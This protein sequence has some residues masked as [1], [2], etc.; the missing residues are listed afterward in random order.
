MAKKNEMT[1][2][3]VKISN[4]PLL[5]KP[6]EEAGELILH[7]MGGTLAIGDLPPIKFPSGGS[8]VYQIPRLD[9]DKAVDLFEAVILYR[10]STINKAYW[11]SITVTKTPPDCRSHDG[12]TGIGDPGGLCANC[13]LNKFGSAL[14]ASGNPLP[15]KAC[16]DRQM[17]F[18]LLEGD[19]LPY[20]L[21]LPPTSLRSFGSFCATL[22]QAARLYYSGI[23][24]VGIRPATSKGGTPYSQA[25]FR[26]ARDKAGEMK[27]FDEEQTAK[28]KALI[29]GDGGRPGLAAQLEAVQAIDESDTNADSDNTN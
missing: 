19:S 22:T 24:E 25:A 7:N 21:N 4:Y 26:I 12:I 1:T 5:L 13:P 3:L 11:K 23:T 28:I 29:Y 16:N 2:A 9:G 15:S 6:P 27:L 10:Q 20:V 8:T 18:P 17:I 14:D